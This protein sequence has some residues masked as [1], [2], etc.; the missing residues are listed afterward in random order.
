MVA[1]GR[2]RKGAAVSKPYWAAVIISWVAVII[3]WLI[4]WLAICISVLTE[5]RLTDELRATQLQ[6]DRA[7]TSL[8]SC[9]QNYEQAQDALKVLQEINRKKVWPKQERNSK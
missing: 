5:R 6:F 3:S 9:T 1:A 7:I 8:G 2:G 4:T